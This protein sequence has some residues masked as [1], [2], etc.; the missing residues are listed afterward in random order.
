MIISGSTTGITFPTT[1]DR[2]WRAK[3]TRWGQAFTNVRAPIKR[4]HRLTPAQAN[5][6]YFTL[7]AAGWKYIESAGLEPAWANLAS[8]ATI[9]TYTQKTKTP[10]PF[11]LFV[12]YNTAHLWVYNNPANPEPYTV[13]S[14]I[15][16]APASFTAETFPDATLQW[17]HSDQYLI[18]GLTSPTTPSSQSITGCPV[19]ALPFP[20]TNATYNYIRLMAG[21]T[22]L[23]PNAAF[24]IT[25]PS[26]IAVPYPLTPLR[27]GMRIIN[28]PTNTPGPRR[29]FGVLP[30]P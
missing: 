25:I 4:L 30:P 15:I 2:T 19:I 13:N 14:L 22:T 23:A 3:T 29:W 5:R 7:Y 21:V 28:Y 8:T 16:N 26:S 1:T 20:G 11:E 27:I 18:N 6:F 17:D 24:N 12:Y 10:S 9:T